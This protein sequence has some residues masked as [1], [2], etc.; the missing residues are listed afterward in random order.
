VVLALTA[1]CIR[2]DPASS[3][4]AG[5]SPAI[6]LVDAALLPETVDELPMTDVAAFEEL[7]GQL[8]GTPV[9]VNFWAAWCEPCESETPRLAQAARDH[10][11]T[12]QFLGVD[13]LDNRDDA[14]AFIDRFDV[15]YPSLFDP[16]GET[17]TSVGSLGQP[18]TVFYDASGVQVAK[19]DGE[20][21]EDAL[22]E[23]LA[24]LIA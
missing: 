21:G 14:R 17:R 5:S 16:T 7:L 3:P 22:R 15:P 9:V 23:H 18:V 8:H 4:D 10:A 13:I 2:D 24:A 19:V 12:I 1:A 11:E 6:R 20:I